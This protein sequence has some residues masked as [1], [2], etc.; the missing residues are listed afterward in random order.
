MSARA[1]WVVLR[2]GGPPDSHEAAFGR[3]VAA[4]FLSGALLTGNDAAVKWLTEDLPVGQIMFLRAA[5]L[6]AGIGVVLLGR[7]RAGLLRVGDWQGQ[8]LRALFFVAATVFFVNGLRF[9]PLADA[10]AITFASPLFTTLLSVPLLGERVRWRRWSAVIVGFLGV[11]LVVQPTGQ[12]LAW[13]ALLPLGSALAIAYVDIAT[14]RLRSTESSIGILFWTTAA[15]ALAGLVTLPFG[16]VWPSALQM[17]LLLLSALLMG[18]ALYLAIEAFRLAEAAS[19]APFRYSSMIWA[20]LFGFLVWGTLPSLAAWSGI[21]LIVGSA[22]YI[23]H[24]EQVRRV[25]D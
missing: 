24:R 23:W 16:W 1:W 11:L 18:G 15:V 12:G 19:I 8:G 7:G 10:T 13:A 2:Q 5:L 17:S 4:M 14:R 21:A 20:V 22:L 9:L 3:A 6:A 25:A